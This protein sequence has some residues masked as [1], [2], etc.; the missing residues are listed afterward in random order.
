MAN[1]ESLAKIRCFLHFF[2]DVPGLYAK[3]VRVSEWSLEQGSG[4]GEVGTARVLR[5]RVRPLFGARKPC[6]A[7]RRR[8][9]CSSPDP[10][11]IS[12]YLRFVPLKLHLIPLNSTWFHLIPLP[13]A[14]P[15]G[16]HGPGGHSRQNPQ[17]RR[18][19]WKW[20]HQNRAFSAVPPTIPKRQI[21]AKEYLF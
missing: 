14:P 4:K 16:G 11:G 7:K 2:L 10:P 15:R 5:P 3:L 8:A 6:R 13:A 9:A 21:K 12:N 17:I 18:N 20:M 1:D 19:S